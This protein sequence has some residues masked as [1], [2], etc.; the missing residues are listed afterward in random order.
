MRNRVTISILLVLGA[1][2]AFAAA[3]SGSKT[4]ENLK[5]TPAPTVALKDAPSI[6]CDAMVPTTERERLLP[7]RTVTHDRSCADGKCFADAC[8]YNGKGKSVHVLYDCRDDADEAMVRSRAYFSTNRIKARSVAGLG[9]SA[10]VDEEGLSF[11]DDEAHCLVTIR[12]EGDEER[13]IELARLIETNLTATSL[14][15]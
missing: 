6:D 1:T 10:A 9:S 13:H 2:A 12:A 5:P 11:F 3:C 8:H 4:K 15:R 14:I 7:G